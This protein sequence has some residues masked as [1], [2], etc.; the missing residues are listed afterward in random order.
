M[1]EQTE[2]VFL[3]RRSNFTHQKNLIETII[4]V[5][6]V[7]IKVHVLLQFVLLEEF[8]LYCYLIGNIANSNAQMYQILSN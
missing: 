6:W 5:R 4:N 7:I 1:T 8:S 2:E 3:D